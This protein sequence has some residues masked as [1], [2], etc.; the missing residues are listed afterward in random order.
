MNDDKPPTTG[1]PRAVLKFGGEVVADAAGLHT[2]LTEVSELVRRGW[3]IA[4]V[5]GGGP[6]S[7]AQHERLGIDM[8]KVAGRR[9]TTPQTLEV[10]KQILAGVVNVD[11]VAAGRAVGLRC[12]GLCGASLIEAT[13]RPPEVIDGSHIDYGL[14]GEVARVDTALIETLWEAGRIPVIAP[15]GLDDQAQ[16]YNINAD[17]VAAGIAASLDA[18]H[19]FL[20]TSAGGVLADV[21][22]P[23]SRIPTLS[24]TQ[25]RVAIADGT[26]VGGMIP[27]VADALDQFDHGMGVVH[28]LGVGSLA[29][30]ARDPGSVGTA[31]F[32]EG[33]R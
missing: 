29:Q 15:L 26:I 13:R 22:D 31:I 16:A 19:L 21:D 30:A 5:H 4:I 32:A 23:R 9:V 8:R 7:D 2:V 6:Q 24:P 11:V 17:T 28:I 1:T 18:Q 33:S 20:M 27:K 3:S 25:A 14:V 10:A 12:V